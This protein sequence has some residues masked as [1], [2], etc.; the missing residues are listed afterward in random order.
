[1]TELTGRDALRQAGPRY[2]ELVADEPVTCR[3][4]WLQAWV[5]SY[6][7]WEPWVVLV[8]GAAAALARRKRGPVTQV[9]VLG[10]GPS[11]E[12][13]LPARGGAA[14]A[15][16]AEAVV[17]G[18]PARWSLRAEQLPPD[19]PVLAELVARCPVH[20][21]A[22]GDGLPRV[23]LTD[24]WRRHVSRNSRQADSRARR[25]LA[26]AGYD[27][28]ETRTADPAEIAAAMPEVRAVHRARDLA[29]GRRPDHDDPRAAA[30]HAAVVAAH[31]VDLYL[32]RANGALAAYVLG[33]RDRRSLAVWDNRVNPDF[34]RFS[35][36]RVANTAILREAVADP[37]YDVLD[38]MRG[39]E[40]YKLSSA[41][42][43]TP[44]VQLRAW[45]HGALRLPYAASTRARALRRQ[46]PLAA[47]AFSAL[48]KPQP[49]TPT[50]PSADGSRRA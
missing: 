17:A 9:C 45:S 29:A 33:V 32:L 43:V 1:M 2:D 31:D 22:P 38:W 6:S 15:R 27:L 13:R 39:V 18:L 42:R 4:P 36:G 30:F 14:A 40:T 25:Q 12:S 8:D 47:R 20:V 46:S 37:A 41:T 11:D 3:R 10:T 16:L 50:G 24:D 26:E 35:A 34:Q 7:D 19:C 21:L 23:D 44:T 48:G 49:R 28:T 5:D